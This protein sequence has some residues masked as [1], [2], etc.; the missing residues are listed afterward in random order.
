MNG[1]A[2][3]AEVF[4]RAFDSL[5]KPEK[6]VVISRLLDD[7]QLREEVLDIGHIED[8]DSETTGPI[9]GRLEDRVANEG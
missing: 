2:N 3:R 9:E 4:L 5:S 1:K 8:C 7:P 6:R